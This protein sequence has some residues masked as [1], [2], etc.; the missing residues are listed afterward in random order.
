MADF[1]TKDRFIF[2]SMKG[3]KMKKNV[4]ALALCKLTTCKHT[5]SHTP[6]PRSS[7]KKQ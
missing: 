3:I 1:S 6:E 7:F 2:L 5:P 4:L